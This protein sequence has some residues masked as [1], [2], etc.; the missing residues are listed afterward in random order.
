MTVERRMRDA[1]LLVLASGGCW[2]AS[3]PSTTPPPPPD[4]PATTAT[5]TTTTTTVADPWTPGRIDPRAFEHPD[6]FC[7]DY[8]R[9]TRV[10]PTKATNSPASLT[11]GHGVGLTYDA[12]RSERMRRDDAELDGATRTVRCRLV[13]ESIPS[14]RQTT[15]TP[16]CCPS[17]RG[18]RPCPPS[19]IVTVTDYKLLVERAVLQFDGTLVSSTLSWQLAAHQFRRHNCGRRPEGLAFDGAPA[20]NGT[21]A[22][23]AAMA[24]LEAASIPA[25]ARLARELAHHGAPA[26]LVA[27][28]RAAMRDEI[29]HA[30]VL[31]ELARRA[32]CAPRSLDLP[33]LPIRT[34]D[35]IARE[36]AVEG[37]VHE[38]FGALVATF[39]AEC[40]ALPV[41][42]VFAQIAVDEQRHAALAEDVHAWLASRLEPASL[43]AV[44]AARAHAESDLR[45]SLTAHTACDALGLPGPHDA[46]AM[47]D[48]Y[49][50]A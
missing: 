5:T 34:L 10:D 4:P 39:Q 47:F 17:G 26:A 29:R 43:A 30:R 36:N 37:C 38:A 16:T 9:R 35:G 19:Q 25:F 32:G 20:G 12:D 41:R 1:V 27:R 15:H 44:D 49:F 45:A 28:A 31:G 22:Q 8:K 40:A 18:N 42:G 6:A 24:E 13:R 50:A 7:D 3:G 23:L 14:Q 33:A 2:H 48:A 11:A 46:R 21:A